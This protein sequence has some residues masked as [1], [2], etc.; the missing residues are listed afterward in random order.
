[1]ADQTTEVLNKG[2]YNAV[3]AE[4]IPQEASSDALGWISTDDAIELSRGRI[5]HGLE[6]NYKSHQKQTSFNKIIAAGESDANGKY[7]KVAQKFRTID[8]EGTELI[9]KLDAVVLYKKP[10]TGVIPDGD[11]ITISVQAEV[12]SKPS[13]TALISKVY[14]KDQWN[15]VKTGFFQATFA[16]QYELDRETNYWIVAE[17]SNGDDSNHINFGFVDSDVY[18][19]GEFKF[20]STAS[21]WNNFTGDLAFHVMEESIVEGGVTGHHVSYKVNGD[22]VFLKKGGTAIQYYD[23]N[24]D[25]YFDLITGLTAEKDIAITDHTSLAGN[26][27]YIGGQ[28]GL[29]KVSVA[30]P[31]AFTDVYDSAKNF[32]G[33]MFIDRSR[34]ILWDR[35]ADRT[36]LYGSKIDPQDGTVYTTVAAESLGALGSTL[37][38]GTLAFKAG[39]DKRTC[40]GL[41][42]TASYLDGATTKTETFTDD[43]SGNLTSEVGGTGTINYMTGTFEVTFGKTTTTAPVVDYQ[44]EDSTDGGIVD[45]TKSAPR[46]AAEGF[47]FRQDKGGDPILNVFVQEGKYISLKERSSYELTLG[48]DDTT[49]TNIP[50]R[51][52]I[53]MPYWKAGITSLDGVIFLNTANPD[54]PKLTILRRVSTA[55]ILEPVSLAEQFDFSLYNWDKCWME[56][57]NEYIVFTGRNKDSDNNDVLFVYNARL[58]SMDIL[59]FDVNTLV[60]AEGLLYAGSSVNHSVSKVLNGFDDDG[61][62][63]SNHWTSRNEL[64]DTQSLKKL[65]RLQFRGRLSKEQKIKVSIQYDN[66]SFEEVGT[67]LGDGSYVDRTISYAVGTAGIGTATVGGDSALTSSPFLLEIK[68]TRKPKFRGRKLKFEALGIGYASIDKFTDYDI[69][70]YENKLPSKY[71]LKQNVSLDG[72][73]TDQ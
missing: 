7:H 26:F 67:I 12:T 60:K 68:L 8:E 45:F 4:N 37:Y 25:A 55:S 30:N 49:A 48:D 66:D 72:E 57:Y 50:F 64:F 53:G 28:D 1:M 56:T 40:F 3:N 69:I 41:I 24:A 14:T 35:E 43:Y 19:D 38:T 36:G 34:M 51:D 42:V 47:V 27:A 73:S 5:L 10:D 59:P 44:W 16:S 18:T 39:G 70:E 33:K 61:S 46:Q 32:K 58:N 23:E 52:S 54:K 31:E 65:R 29:W 15:N 2:V 13:G 62:V 9:Q 63:V 71:R 6:K 21:G 11:T 20:Y 22:P 17:T